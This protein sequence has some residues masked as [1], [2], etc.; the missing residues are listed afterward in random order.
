MQGLELLY[1]LFYTVYHNFKKTKN[2]VFQHEDNK[3]R[4]DINPMSPTM[5]KYI[6]GFNVGSSFVIYVSLSILLLSVFIM[7]IL[8]TRFNRERKEE[9]KAE[10]F[11]EDWVSITTESAPVARN[12]HSAVWTGEEMLIWGGQI[13]SG[14]STNSGKKYDPSSNVWSDMTTEVE[15]PSARYDHSTV[16]TG[17]EMIVWGGNAGGTYANSGARYA[18]AANNWT[19]MS[20]EG[21]P[22]GRINHT[23]VWT[24]EKM[25]VWGGKDKEGL[26]NTGASYDPATDT[27]TALTTESVPSARERH[28]AIWTGE[29]MVVWGGND[30]S[31]TNTG[32]RYS[33]SEE[34]WI[35]LS[36]EEAPESREDHTAVWTGEEM[37]VWGGSA[38]PVYNN[39][40]RY[41]PVSNEWSSVTTTDAP[42]ART[43]HTAVWTGNNMIIWG[44]YG[45]PTLQSGGVYDPSDNSW[46]STS[47]TSAPVSRDNHTALWADDEMII[48]GGYG[49]DFYNTGGRLNV[50]Y[51]IKSLDA[52]LDAKDSSGNNIEIDS[53]GGVAGSAT[54]H[55]ADS[56]NNFKI[57]E[58]SGVAFSDDL[59]WS[60]LSADSDTDSDKSYIHVAGDLEGFTNDIVFYVP[61][62]AEDDLVR[63]CPNAQSME[64]VELACSAG[65]FLE[66]DETESGI[67]A[68]ATTVDAQD[69][70]QLDGVSGSGGVSFQTTCGDGLITGAEECDDDGTINGDG[71]SATCAVESG[72]N[73]SSEPS[74]CSEIC[75]DGLIV[76][77]EVCDSNSTSCTTDDGYDGTKLCNATCNGWKVCSS[78]EFCGDGTVNGEEECDD[79]N[80]TNDDG[81]SSECVLEDELDE[82]ESDDEESSDDSDQTDS[83]QAEDSDDSEDDEGGE[84]QKVA[85]SDDSDDDSLPDNWELKYDCVDESKNDAKGD[86]DQD[87]LNNLGEYKN[88]TDPCESDTDGDSYL[89]GYEVDKKTDPKDSSSFPDL[90]KA[91]EGK[92]ED[93]ISQDFQLS[94]FF[95]DVIDFK[96]D[97]TFMVVIIYVFIAFALSIRF[98]VPIMFLGAKFFVPGIL[99]RTT[100]TLLFKR[101]FYGVVIGKG[102]LP[103]SFALIEAKSLDDRRTTKTVA[104]LNGEYSLKLEKGKY[105]IS[106]SQNDYKTL[107]KEIIQKSSEFLSE[108]FKLKAKVNEGRLTMKEY[109]ADVCKYFS[110]L[111]LILTFGFGIIISLVN[112]GLLGIIGTIM[113]LLL[114]IWGVLNSNF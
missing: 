1:G 75:G 106:V 87:Y 98:I 2:L 19:S 103:V 85:K 97:Y 20:V 81:C 46:T 51:Q 27:W 100:Y 109:L 3:N 31:A 89:D 58:F 94:N 43:F 13:D 66:D 16:W 42:S 93:L 4:K 60:N 25:I 11:S 17:E 65:F 6:K 56:D 54:V 114:G 44:G 30:G 12:E 76:G 104:N 37:I 61:R 71:C 108:T 34:A 70:W 21:A 32:G 38:I 15:P 47:T 45:P 49:A 73:C 33:P 72:W 57:A 107:N 92:D 40:G 48:W 67:T 29:M 50:N 53:S 5:R 22:D 79:G 64:D 112:L 113:A 78:S 59:T 69:V 39:G 83:G 8:F 18:P 41:N 26:L 28:T 90:L 96:F 36:T 74:V 110:V 62:D 111:L 88:G 52:S 86:P 99:L 10:V 9:G 23:A 55:L 63:Y 102:N 68:D 7:G 80:N 84:T 101:K 77:D 24:G 91:V 14:V 95:D 82:D 105:E 35:G